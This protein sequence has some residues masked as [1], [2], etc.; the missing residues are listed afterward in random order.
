VFGLFSRDGRVDVW[1]CGKLRPLRAELDA[2]AFQ[3]ARRLHGASDAEVALA[4]LRRLGARL[5]DP[6]PA[7]PAEGPLCVVLPAALGDLPVGAL[8]VDG[9]AL[10]ERCSVYQAPTAAPHAPAPR[11]G[12][13]LLVGIEDQ[14]LP[15]VRREIGWLAGRL[16][17]ATRLEGDDAFR[18]A[19][20]AGIGR[21]GIVHLAGHA[22]TRADLPPLSALPL[23]DGRLTASDLAGTAM[24]GTLIVLSACRTGDPSLRWRGEAMAGFPRALLA[25]GADAVVASRWEVPDKVAF[26]WMRALYPR[27]TRTAPA[28]AVTEAAR[29]MKREFRHPADWAA[30]LLIRP[31]T[32]E[33]IPS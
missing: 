9:A 24:R 32:I 2:F 14:A 11:P 21:H 7:L 15:D 4:G 10:F 17:G 26:A 30:F 25:A 8:P 20:L 33:E 13:A 18:S 22:E 16:P 28:R 23:R 27:L 31:G 12:G 6:A 29:A 5:L 1:R 19:V 3:V